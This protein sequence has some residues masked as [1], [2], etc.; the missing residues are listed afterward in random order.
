MQIFE[1]ITLITGK[2]IGVDMRW[3]SRVQWTTQNIS[4][5]LCSFWI[6]NTQK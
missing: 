2:A 5:I 4:S 6:Q 1:L 3:E